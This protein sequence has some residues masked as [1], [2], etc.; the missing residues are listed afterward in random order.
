MNPVAIFRHSPT[1]GPGYFAI[2]LETHRIPWQLIAIDRNDPLPQS[3]EAFSG[4]CFMGGTMS[5]NDSLPWIP[6]V[7][8][9][10]L[11]A[12]QKDLPVIGHCLGGQ[13]LSKALGGSIQKNPTPEIGWGKIQANSETPTRH[14][15]GDLAG[16]AL[17]V[18]QWHSETFSLPEGAALLASSAFCPQQIFAVGPHLGMQCHIEMLPEMIHTWCA[19]W[20]APETP[21]AA[22]ATPEEILR[23]LPEKLPALRKTANQLYGMWLQGLRP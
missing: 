14:W 23:A 9:L 4:L 17:D 6:A 21:C 19:H 1:E 13:L 5:V 15:L 7:C 11:E 12:Y 10:I 22:I 16:K 2:F 3:A 8:D 18:F 20:S